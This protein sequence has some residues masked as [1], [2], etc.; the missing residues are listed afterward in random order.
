MI[1]IGDITSLVID[2]R[3]DRPIGSLSSLKPGNMVTA[4]I[5]RMM[6]D[7]RMELN[8]GRFQAE[9]HYKGDVEPGQTL[10]LKVVSTGPPLHLQVIPSDPTRQVPALP[11]MNPAGIISPADVDRFS[12]LLTRL[13]DLFRQGDAP[14][15]EQAVM[16]LKEMFQP[17]ALDS[18]SD[19]LIGRLAG[20]IED[21]GLF[22][23]KK[24]F[25][26]LV[27]LKADSINI[28]ARKLFLQDGGGPVR[29]NELTALLGRDLKNQLFLLRSFLQGVGE[30]SD[31]TKSITERQVDF[32]KSVI[33]HLFEHI[34][35]QQDHIIQR[36][37]LTENYQIQTHWF[38]VEG[39]DH[40]L[41]LKLYYPKNR[42]EDHHLP[43]QVCL[44]LHLDALGPLRVDFSMMDRQLQIVFSVMDEH[45]REF[46]EIRTEALL[47]TLEGMF[48]QVISTVRVAPEKIDAFDSEDMTEVEK[49]RVDIRA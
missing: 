2:S 22:W 36:H 8:F 1:G 19:G 39:Q 3:P 16:Q 35:A 24:V 34:E 10:Q 11:Q 7:Q 12:A 48:S 15:L 27:Q 25:D 47:K 38:P 28:D 21:S 5:V 6:S 20:M 40:P 14:R 18:H 45:L 46:V 33:G 43:Q 30:T 44:L 29:G 9:A 31:P 23:E 32:L 49:G 37:N 13:P 42:R 4:R 26:A 41:K 17:I